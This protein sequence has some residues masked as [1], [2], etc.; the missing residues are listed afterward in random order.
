MLRLLTAI[1][2]LLFAVGATPASALESNRITSPH[3]TASLVSEVD[4]VVPGKAF[5][6]GLHLQLAP[7]WHT[8][9]RNPGDSGLPTKVQWHA[10]AAVKP[11]DIAWPA[12]QR[13]AVGG[14]YN[15]GYTGDVVLPVPVQVAASAKPG[16][17]ARLSADV[18]WLVCREECVP[19][20][21][22][23]HLDLP[24][25]ASATANARSRS[26]AAI[27]AE[28]ASGRRSSSAVAVGSAALAFSTASSMLMTWWPIETPA[29]HSG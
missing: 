16:T 20:K 10:P 15:F 11:G 9:W 2:L 14:L 19:G 24:I 3:D 6:I 27:S 13:F 5:R 23:L 22:T 12:P 29:S 7:G 21:A 18:R 25:A 8:Y 4:T 17:T 26:L 1:L 28:P